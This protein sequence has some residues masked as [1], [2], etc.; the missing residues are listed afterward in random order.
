MSRIVP[1]HETSCWCDC[2]CFLISLEQSCPICGNSNPC[3]GNKSL[4]E[5][6]NEYNDEEEPEE[7]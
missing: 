4:A 6:D 7:L 5:L 3:Y 1:Y 2:G